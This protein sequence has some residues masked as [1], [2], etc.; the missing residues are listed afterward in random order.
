MITDAQAIALEDFRD[1]MTATSSVSVAVLETFSEVSKP[2]SASAFSVAAS[3]QGSEDTSEVSMHCASL[4]AC[5]A[6]LADRSRLRA[7]TLVTPRSSP[8]V[9]VS[10]PEGRSPE[11]FAP[12]TEAAFRRD[13]N[14]NSSVKVA[15]KEKVHSVPK[16]SV[17]VGDRVL[18][19]PRVHYLNKTVEVPELREIEK[20]VEIPQ[21][22]IQEVVKHV[23]RVIVQEIVRHV[24]KIE[25]QEVVRTVPKV[26]V[27]YVEKIVEVPEIRTVEKI[28]EVPQTR[29]VEKFV[30]V[31]QIQRVEVEKRVHVPARPTEVSLELASTRLPMQRPPQEIQVIDTVSLGGVQVALL[32]EGNLRTMPPDRLREHAMNLYQAIG[33]ANIGSGVPVLEADLVNWILNVQRCHLDSL[34]ASS[35]TGSLKTGLISTQSISSLTPRSVGYSAPRSAGYTKVIDRMASSAAALGVTTP[36]S[37]TFAAPS[38]CATQTV[39]DSTLVTSP[40]TARPPR[41]R[42]ASAIAGGDRLVRSQAGEA[43]ARTQTREVLA[44]TMSLTPGRSGFPHM[45]APLV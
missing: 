41:A 44:A 17:Q 28:I 42:S 10:S 27:Q 36:A 9:A 18:E 35:S 8:T 7:E 20:V 15:T 37:P 13:I 33:Y 32:S 31:P 3:V 25:I 4:E 11:A 34:Q 24:P 12:R 39:A 23:P 1:G 26:Q 40:M 21:V 22:Q 16:L 30:E 45:S 19:V 29:T 2:V 43:L 14:F 5:L 38:L 6:S